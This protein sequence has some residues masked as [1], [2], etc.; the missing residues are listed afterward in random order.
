MGA[1]LEAFVRSGGTIVFFPP[2]GSDAGSF[3]GARWHEVEMAG[4]N[5]SFKA[6][7]WDEQDGPFAKTEEGANLPVS[8]LVVARRQEVIGEKNAWAA[9]S[10]AKPFLSHRSLGAGQVL[11]CAT[12]PKTDWSD[13]GGGPVLVPMMQRLIQD[14]GRRFGPAVSVETGDSGALG[15]FS[16][17]RCVDSDRPK[18]P[19]TDAGVYRNGE[20]LIAVNRPASED[21]SERIEPSAARKLF[22]PATVQLFE[23]PKGGSGKLQG[24]VWRIAL[25]LMLAV[26]LLEGWL[27]LPVMAS[28]PERARHPS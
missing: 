27:T 6:A 9:F 2:G 11:F 15:E 23:E 22:A 20:R 5:A 28:D 26:L 1:A 16:A 8:D 25:G 4:D 21:E 3:G 12:L 13:L 24:E 18:D 17:W 19:R 14:A 10:D 7:Q